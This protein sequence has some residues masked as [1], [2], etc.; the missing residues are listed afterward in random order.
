MKT[1][2]LSLVTALALGSTAYAVDLENIKVSGQATLYYQ[3]MTNNA[4]EPWYGLGM[5]GVQGELE[6]LKQA[7]TQDQAAISA[8]EAEVSKTNDKLIDDDKGLFHKDSSKANVGFS[9]RFE[10]ELGNDFG[11][12]A[13][14]NV[15]ETLGLEHNLVSG[16]MQ[17]INDVKTNEFINVRTSITSNNEYNGT[18]G[19]DGDEW[20][21]GEAYLTKKIGKTTLKAGRQ[22]LDTP[23]VFSEK[24]N[25]MPI[26][27]DAIVL[28]NQ[29][30]QNLTLVGA[31]VSKANNHDNLG[32]FSTLAGGLAVDG[33]YAV[34]GIYNN[35]HAT[36]SGWFYNVPSV[37]NGYWVEAN[38][39]A[40]SNADI[41]FQA[42]GLMWDDDVSKA[43][44][45][46]AFGLKVAYTVIDGT[47]ISVAS[48]TVGGENG[49]HSMSN[50]GTTNGVSGGK[51]KLVTATI[52]GDGDVAGAT[53]TDSYKVALKQK[54]G[55]YGTAIVSVAQYIHDKDSNSTYADKTATVFEAVYKQKIGGVDIL[56]AYMYD[57]NVD[58][59]TV[60]KSD[61]DE[62]E[63]AHTLR[64]VLRYNF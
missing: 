21:W 18:S 55:T 24:W 61:E 29:D 26:T 30:I 20:Y 28:L 40:V 5:S 16:T 31:Y 15:L 11:F 41:T 35:G 12:G 9:V 10:S 50:L 23:L 52:S 33:A 56:G 32:Q 38:T 64:L 49:S 36:A 62:S 22:E 39:K 7:E 14:L 6:K 25:V 58:G 13:R 8:K 51:T 59:W 54:L 2:R 27:Y 53:K 60:K 34:G 46:T 1:I 48:A 42:G 4:Q 17:G 45:T 43:D 19:L 57:K 44:D 3:T 47:T 63:D 37:I